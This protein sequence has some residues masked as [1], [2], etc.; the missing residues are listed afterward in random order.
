MLVH[1]EVFRQNELQAILSQ[2]ESKSSQAQL[3]R[4]SRGFPTRLMYEKPNLLKINI[5]SHL[6]NKS[7]IT[8]IEIS[9]M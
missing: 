7:K 4:N 1:N 9:S 2:A 5:L 6:E 8:T 3:W